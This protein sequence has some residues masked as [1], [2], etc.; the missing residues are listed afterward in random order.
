MH[1]K[2]IGILGGVAL[3]MLGWLYATE[4]AYFDNTLNIKKLLLIAAAIG[5]GIGI[6]AGLFFSRTDKGD[7]LTRIQTVLFCFFIGVLFVPVI[8]AKTNRYLAE[9]TPRIKQFTF[10]RQVPVYS[11]PFGQ[12]KM[13]KFTPTYFLIYLN[14]GNSESIRLKSTKEWLQNSDKGKTIDLPV[15]KGY[16]GYDIVL[17]PENVIKDAGK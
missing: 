16:W 17:V 4:Y 10:L 7:N 13:E 14:T 11:K 1:N 5:G 2:L 3:I 8:A 9:E 15:K 6:L 12:T